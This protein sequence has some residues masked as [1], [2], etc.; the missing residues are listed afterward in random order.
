MTRRE[1]RQQTF[2]RRNDD[3]TVVAKRARVRGL[4]AKVT[5]AIVNAP[6]AFV[7]RDLNAAI[8]IRRYV[9]LKTKP[10]ELA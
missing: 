4:A 7:N 10:A 2:A 8:N 5:L 9:V 1:R 6:R 3:E